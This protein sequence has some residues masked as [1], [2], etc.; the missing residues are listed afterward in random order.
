MHQSLMSWSHM[1]LLPPGSVVGRLPF[2]KS[3]EMRIAEAAFKKFDLQDLHG[4]RFS[5]RIQN[6]RK[7]SNLATV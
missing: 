5:H 6:Q 1:V 4:N 2:Y 7:D 3:K